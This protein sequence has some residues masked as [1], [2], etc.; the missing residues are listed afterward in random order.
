MLQ[1]NMEIIIV[2]SVIL[3]AV[4][5]N[6]SAIYHAAKSDMFD[7][8]QLIAQTVLVFFVPF[9]AAI[10]ILQLVFKHKEYRVQ[11]SSQTGASAVFYKVITLAFIGGIVSGS[12]GFAGGDGSEGGS[13]F[14][15]G[16]GGSG[17]GDG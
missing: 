5:L 2:V 8:G 1:V 6:I 4:W 15:G 11:L 10:F 16:D 12:G 7:R 3:L 14:G 13:D 17:G 9:I